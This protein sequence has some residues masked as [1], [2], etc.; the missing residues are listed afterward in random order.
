MRQVWLE[1][2][3]SLDS[4]T[5]DEALGKNVWNVNVQVGCESQRQDWKPDFLTPSFLSYNTVGEGERRSLKEIRKL[6][7]SIFWGNFIELE[8]ILSIF[9]SGVTFHDR[10]RILHGPI[11]FFCG[12]DLVQDHRRL[13]VFVSECFGGLVRI[14][15]I[16]WIYFGKPSLWGCGAWVWEVLGGFFSSMGR[17]WHCH[18]VSSLGMIIF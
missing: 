1:F 12:G 3:F 14:L 11:S 10:M 13:E 5:V 2:S 9:Y 18:L 6:T 4:V 7:P 8:S 15:L 16:V 17:V